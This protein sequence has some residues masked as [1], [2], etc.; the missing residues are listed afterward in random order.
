MPTL[1]ESDG[2]PPKLRPR[3]QHPHPGEPIPAMAWPT[4]GLGACAL[5]VFVAAT[6]GAVGHFIPAWV[7]VAANAA[8]A[9]VMFV[10]AHEGLHWSISTTR[11]V[12]AVIG[13][14]AW[15]FVVPMVSWSSYGHIHNQHHRHANDESND[16]DVF[17]THRPAWQM[18][19]RWAL[20]E[21]FY[22]AWYVRRVPERLRH[23]WRHPV[24]EI[25]EGAV[26]FSVYVGGICAAVVTGHFWTL[27][28][29][30][31]IPQRLGVMILGWWFDWLPHHGLEH[32]QRDD[33]YRA[34]RMRLGAEWLLTPLMLSQNYHSVHHL[35][36]WVPFYRYRQAWRRNEDA[37]LEHGVPIVGPLGRQLTADEVR[38]MRQRDG[39]HA[40]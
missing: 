20:M 10:I 9:F 1:A 2:A 34:S 7:T 6:V 13:R 18:P 30:V 4:L 27:A 16:P 5:T 25:A 39:E 17:A 36:P 22:A 26:V 37:Y 3:Q 12:N 33:R 11:W 14:L 19:F 38:A 28:V 24:A 15:L 31:L 8:V 21:L 35:H 29:A 23:S 32:T 40:A